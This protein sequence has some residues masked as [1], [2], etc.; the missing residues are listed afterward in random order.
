MS[1]DPA[2][3][4]WLY[5]DQTEL[6]SELRVGMDWDLGTASGAGAGGAGLGMG[7]GGFDGLGNW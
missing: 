5:W 4:D 2:A 1:T 6:A 3:P 7:M